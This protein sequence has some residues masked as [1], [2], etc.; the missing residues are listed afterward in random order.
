[1]SIPCGGEISVHFMGLLSPAFSQTS[2]HPSLL[3]VQPSTEQGVR[4]W[5]E[6][7]ES[8]LFLLKGQELDRPVMENGNLMLV[9][10]AQRARYHS[11][12]ITR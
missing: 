6:Q 2:S 4:M 3:P 8:I 7:G 9:H 10:S 11:K 1:M 5:L 12:F